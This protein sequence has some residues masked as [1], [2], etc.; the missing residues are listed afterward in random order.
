[1]S[2][3]TVVPGH[4][5][6]PAVTPKYPAK[7]SVAMARTVRIPALSVMALSFLSIGP[8]VRG[9]YLRACLIRLA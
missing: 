6:V 2:S 1:M 8:R 9:R 5:V 3:A 7:P 4:P